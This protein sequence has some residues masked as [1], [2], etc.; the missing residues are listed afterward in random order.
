MNVY[1]Y[2]CLFSVAVICLVPG[3]VM[4]VRAFSFRPTMNATLITGIVFWDEV[5]NVQKYTVTVSIASS[6][7]VVDDVSI[8]VN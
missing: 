4:N 7:I 2:H 5:E 3:Q 6:G 8:N 1:I